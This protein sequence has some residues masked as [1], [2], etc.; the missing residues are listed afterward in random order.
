MD[1]N[2]VRDTFLKFF[3]DRGHVAVASEGLIPHHPLAPLFSN[4]GMNQFLPYFLGEEDA[5]YKRAVSS[6]KCVRVK[7]KHDDIDQI[8]RTRRHGTFFEMLGNFSFGDYFKEQ[9]IKWHWEL[10]TEGYG[11]DPNRIWITVHPTD[12]EAADIW[13]DVVGIPRERIQ[14]DEEN[15]WEMGDTGPCGPCSE[16]YYDRGET[17]GQ[18]GGPIGGD[19]E[20]YL[21][22]ANI[23]FT[24]Y[25]RQAD[26]SLKD[27]PAKNIDQ[28]SGMERILTIVQDV[29]SF[30]ET[31][32]FRPLIA[33]AEELTGTTYGK[34]TEDDVSLR[35][36]ADH[37][38]SVSFLT[39]D[40]V[41]PSNEDRGYVLRRVTRR[42]LRHAFKLGAKDDVMPTMVNEVVRIM[43]TAYP[44]LAKNERFI[45]DVLQREERRFRKTLD[46]GS[47]L[48]EEELAKS[49]VVAGDAAFRLHDTYGFPV[50]LTKEIAAERGGDVDMEG[51]ATAMERQREM[52]RANAKG[53][54]DKGLSTETYKELADSAGATNFVGYESEE[55]D[56]VVV[57]VL[58]VPDTDEVEIFLKETPFY[59]EQGGQVGDTGYITTDTGAA[60][61]LDT[62]WALP[63][64][65][66]HRATV[67]DGH[68]EANQEAHAAIDVERR[69]AIKRNHTG[70]HVLH[71]ALRKVL[72]DHVKQAG[73]LVAPDRLR[74]DFSHFEA[75]TEEEIAQI[76]DLANNEILT[77]DPVEIVHLSKQAAADA[78]A[79]AFFGEK[80]GETV[81][82]LR[83]G[84]NSLE[85]CGGTHV[86]ALGKIGPLKI[87]SEASIGSN[88]R[89][90][91][92]VTGTGAL[93]Y[94]NRQSKALT[95]AA[96]ALKTRPEEVTDAVERTIAKQRELDNEIKSLRATLRKQ[97]AT[98]I[99]A[100]ATNGVYVGRVDQVGAN[101]LRELA[102]DV[103][104][105]PQITTVALV[106]TP[107]GS[108]VSLVL[109]TKDDSVDAGQIIAAAAKTVGG[110]GG[111]GKD[112]AMAGGRNTAGID[113]AL[114]QISAALGV[115]SAISA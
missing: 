107:D 18:A 87:V 97:Q 71:W 73:S 105:Q 60:K 37:S 114:A 21:E 39:S 72:G 32:L 70:T 44:E 51:F 12:Q 52:A 59:A 43:G 95:S 40:G 80:Y 9:A 68:I 83:A 66:R 77:D 65:S 79:I 98:T 48:L 35:I 19:E 17:F 2:Q 27:L 110:G 54:A 101:E 15:F 30:W 103:R 102:T 24:G 13:A 6:Q 49:K 115:D 63:T 10:M 86:E 46:A 5:P 26:G 84:K 29:D 108:S 62:T 23:V 41:F 53:A 85:L 81:R 99:A 109:A 88:L 22:F 8:G 47:K 94:F 3:T 4:A 113:D 56:T 104:S 38:R 111:K 50:E 1:A 67:V 58:P 33:R 31:D 14:Q 55:V 89:R 82:M 90:V 93:E 96:R 91:E 112:F 7:G 100:R 92:A 64:L 106:G 25:D 57:A 75:V 16:M 78:G 36:I 34:D 69:A 42:L 76:E 74:F 45:A 11:M 20:R 28:G 61:V